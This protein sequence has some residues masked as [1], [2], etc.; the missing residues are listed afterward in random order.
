MDISSYY[1]IPLILLMLKLMSNC[2]KNRLERKKLK[3][4]AKKRREIRDKN[5]KIAAEKY[6]PM[7]KISTELKEK[8]LNSDATNLLK[9]MNENKVSP[10]EILLSYFERVCTIGLELELIAD[11]NIDWAVKKAIEC[12]NKRQEYF[13][14]NKNPEELG[15]PLNFIF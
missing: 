9:M 15:L 1:Y 13:K 14:L 7:L 6:L 10:L 3:E 5:L 4:I 12:S 8:I 11:I 2:L